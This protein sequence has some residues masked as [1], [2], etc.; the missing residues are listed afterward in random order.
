MMAEVKRIYSLILLISFM[1][2]AIQPIVPLMEYHFFKESIMELFCVERDVPDSDCDGFCY[3][4]SQI[5]ESEEQ[6]H[7]APGITSEFYPGGVLCHSI[8]APSVTARSGEPYL[9]FDDR[10]VDLILASNSP[11][12]KSS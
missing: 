6:R 12:P 8:P 11:P 5:S 2:G 7:D 10:P 9:L 4:T 3:L 1:V